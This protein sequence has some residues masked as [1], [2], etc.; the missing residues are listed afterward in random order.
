VATEEPQ[1]APPE[2]KLRWYQYRL[3]SL[4]VLTFLVAVGMSCVATTRDWQRRHREMVEAIGSMGGRVSYELTWL[5]K[6]LRQESLANVIYVDLRRGTLTEEGM[7]HLDHLSQ[8]S[9]LW[10]DHSNITDVG[11]TH[12]EGL[13]QLRSLSLKSTEVTDAG[14]TYLRRLSKLQQLWL[15]DTRVTDA[16]LVR[17]EGM[18]QLCWLN[19]SNTKVTDEGVKKLRK[20]LPECEIVR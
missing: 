12:L 10:L 18:K 13:G 20:A 5:G 17:L 7:A 9:L 16:G 11:L 14:L 2:P 4:F 1:P 3:R 8:L 6:R 15:D 19:L